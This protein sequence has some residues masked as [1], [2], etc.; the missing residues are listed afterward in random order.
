MSQ[1]KLLQVRL[2]AAVIAYMCVVII[3]TVRV[4]RQRVLTAIGGLF[5]FIGDNLPP[6]IR[7]YGKRSPVIKSVL[8]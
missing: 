8:I 5:F 6:V 7:D 4:Q 1:L 2:V 3:I